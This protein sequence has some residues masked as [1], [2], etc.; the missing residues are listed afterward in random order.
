MKNTLSAF[1]LSLIALAPLAHAADPVGEVPNPFHQRTYESSSPQPIAPSWKWS[2]A[3]LVAS[4]AMDAASSYGMRELNPLLAGP[5]GQFGIKATLLK[6]GVTAALVGA[7]YL[8]VKAH[9]RAAKIFTKINWSGA[10]LTG[11]FAAHN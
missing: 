10:A 7:E 2:L 5:E 1:L 11:A 3:P 6:A 4:Q 8:I 9:P